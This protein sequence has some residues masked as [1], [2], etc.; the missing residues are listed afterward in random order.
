ME[1]DYIHEYLTAIFRISL[2]NGSNPLVVPNSNKIQV[3]AI[4][5]DPIGARLNF[6][7]FNRPVFDALMS[8]DT[9]TSSPCKVEFDSKFTG[10]DDVD[11]VR[12]NPIYYLYGCFRRVAEIR[13]YMNAITEQQKKKIVRY[14]VEQ[15]V[16]ILVCPFANLYYTEDRNAFDDFFKILTEEYSQE[17]TVRLIQEITNEIVAV[18]QMRT[19]PQYDSN[20]LEIAEDELQVVKIIQPIYDRFVKRFTRYES[21][22]NSVFYNDINL[23]N[24]FFASPLVAE[25]FLDLN[26]PPHLL[27]KPDPPGSNNNSGSIQDLNYLIR[28]SINPSQSSRQ[29]DSRRDRNRKFLEDSLLG[30]VLSC[31]CLPSK[32][33]PKEDKNANSGAEPTQA[34]QAA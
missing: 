29:Q 19:A 7:D 10:Y 6:E 18:N 1:E 34:I 21:Q 8:F 31:S 12:K 20:L 32:H 30:I 26:S 15:I 27:G 5:V 16:F 4:A 9:N 2:T 3:S 23:L 25:T 14:I 24:I 28:N 13:D 11:S 33:S 22:L 17:Q